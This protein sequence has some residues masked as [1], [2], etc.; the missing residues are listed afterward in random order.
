MMLQDHRQARAQRKALFE[1]NP[2]NK[3]AKKFRATD[4]NLLDK[5]D[6]NRESFEI[7]ANGQRDASTNLDPSEFL[8]HSIGHGRFVKKGEA[9]DVE[10]SQVSSMEDCSLE[11]KSVETAGKR[12]ISTL[13][14]STPP[15]LESKSGPSVSML[16]ST[17]GEKK[18]TLVAP[19]SPMSFWSSQ[20]SPRSSSGDNLMQAK[21]KTT[22]VSSTNKIITNG[23]RA[24]A[25]SDTK[26]SL[27]SNSSRAETQSS[28]RVSNIGNVIEVEKEAAVVTSAN[29]IQNNITRPQSIIAGKVNPD[30]HPSRGVWETQSSAQ[31]YSDGNTTK[32]KS[33]TYVV[34]SAANKINANVARPHSFKADSVVSGTTSSRVAWGTQSS[35]RAS[36]DSNTFEEKSKGPVVSSVNK[37][38]DNVVRPQS[39]GANVNLNIKKGPNT[40]PTR[41][42]WE[43]Q[44]PTRASSDRKVIEADSKMSVS[45]AAKKINK[46]VVRPQAF[47]ADEENTDTNPSRVLRATQPSPEVFSDSNAIEAKKKATVVSSGERKVIDTKSKMS[48]SSAAK[49]INK[50]VVR[51]QGF[52]ADEENTDTNPSGVLRGTQPPPQV[53]SDSN[54]IEAK[55]EITDVSSVNNIQSQL[56]DS[57]A[58]VHVNK[59]TSIYPTSTKVPIDNNNTRHAQP[60]SGGRVGTSASPRV[61]TDNQTVTGVRPK[62]GS[63]S[64]V[65]SSSSDI[66]SS[67]HSFDA[68]ADSSFWQEPDSVGEGKSPSQQSPLSTFPNHFSSNVHNQNVSNVAVRQKSKGR[69][70]KRQDSSTQHAFDVDAFS[71]SSF[72]PSPQ[73]NTFQKAISPR[74]EEQYSPA[75][76]G[77]QNASVAARRRAKAMNAVTIVDNMSSSYQQMQPKPVQTAPK[78]VAPVIAPPTTSS[79]SAR[80]RAARRNMKQKMQRNNNSR[81]VSES[82]SGSQ[83]GSFSNFAD[84]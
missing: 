20:S 44:S 82:T 68:F 57:D 80:A 5:V 33:K 13:S 11:Q 37:I 47:K 54:A 31:A 36:N 64:V 30:T 21:K 76:S 75:S 42:I 70:E 43:T 1:A 45:S 34:A 81:T 71:E 40:N 18:G 38:Q 50:H 56:F 32:A 74:F 26:K 27:D 10:I 46:H 7:V 17:L 59:H 77:R 24:D 61:K 19:V 28:P 73:F 39:V 65:K 69:T 63:I 67:P 60:L 49:K 14:E 55:K 35:P 23:I 62:A 83:S 48:V 66:S 12:E 3:S 53:F 2:F 79:A 84:F 41:M 52:K 6:A 8:W 16:V 51:P 4:E 9:G 15:K 29:K 22:V 72:T 78:P 25:N 58:A